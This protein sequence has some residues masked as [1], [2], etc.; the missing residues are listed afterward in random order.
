MGLLISAKAFDKASCLMPLSVRNVLILAVVHNV[1]STAVAAATPRIVAN[2]ME[3]D[4]TNR[5]PIKTRE[6]FLILEQNRPCLYRANERC[7]EFFFIVAQ[8]FFEMYHSMYL[9]CLSSSLT[10]H[11]AS[12]ETSSSGDL[13][14]LAGYNQFKMSKQWSMLSRS[15]INMIK[16]PS[17]GHST[18]FLSPSSR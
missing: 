7:T 10:Q 18:S 11:P 6:S 14:C 12:L 3:M 2:V 4:D 16:H 1:P 8:A 5:P 9:S 15:G 17:R 13:T